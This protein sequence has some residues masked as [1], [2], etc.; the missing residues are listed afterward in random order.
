MFSR[1]GLG[2]LGL[3]GGGSSEP[4]LSFTGQTTLAEDFDGVAFTLFVQN[5]PD[6]DP[7]TIFAEVTD[8]D[9]IATLDGDEV[10]IS[11]LD[12]ET[13]TSHTLVYSANSVGGRPE[14]QLTVIIT[15]TDV[16]EVAPLLTNPTDVATSD[17]TADLSVST[18]EGNGTL[19]AVVTQSA[20]PPSAAQVKAGQDH[21]GG[22]ADFADDQAVSSTG[23]KT[24]EATGLTAET[25]YFTYFMHEDA[26]TNQSL[27]SA[28]DGFTTG[29]A[30]GGPDFVLID[31][32]AGTNI[33]DMTAFG[34][35]AAAFDGVTVQGG[36]A[37]ARLSG[38]D[39]Y[40]G[41]TLAAARTF[42]KALVY[43]SNTAGFDTSAG[44]STITLNIYGKNGVAPS[45]RSDGTLLGTLSF[46]DTS[47]ESAGRQI[48]STDLSTTWDHLWVHVNTTTGAVS[49][50]C[51][52]LQLYAWE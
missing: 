28:A 46:T 14:L 8:A 30:G 47:N 7:Y 9:N 26:A 19:Y 38:T 25:A 31:R 48:D 17:T 5:N 2:L 23:V 42:G 11:G 18:D 33:G 4:R 12:F 10:T 43:G 39:G 44:V 40:V 16:D 22:A 50:L 34:G 37:C 24:F 13:A 15:V 29:A 3:A 32:T 21:L 1:F 35:L 41:K 52:E 6:T 20:T 45:S 27:V 36:T 51:A 49:V